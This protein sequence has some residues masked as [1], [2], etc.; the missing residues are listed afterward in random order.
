MLGAHRRALLGSLRALGANCPP[1]GQPRL[2]GSPALPL[3]SPAL[4]VAVV[5]LAAWHALDQGRPVRRRLAGRPMRRRKTGPSATRRA[6]R[7]ADRR[8]GEAVSVAARTARLR[9]PG[10][11]ASAGSDRSGWGCARRGRARAVPGRARPSGRRSIACAVALPPGRWSAD[12]V[13]ENHDLEAGTVPSRSPLVG[14]CSRSA[15]WSLLL[16]LQAP[17][18]CPAGVLANLLAIG[19]AFGADD[20]SSRAAHGSGCSPSSRRAS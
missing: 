14:G 17:R 16:A 7:A 11:R 10:P 12:A 1:R 5:G 3:C 20:S 15:S 9:T 8:P 19:A 18:D 13:A 6:R 2:F 4:G